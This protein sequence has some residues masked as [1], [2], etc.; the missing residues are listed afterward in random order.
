MA[1]WFETR[2]REL[3]D[4]ER[5]DPAFAT[6]IRALVVDEWK[7]NPA[8]I[9]PRH[10][11]FDVYDA[12]AEPGDIIMLD[13]EDPS[14][15]E[16]PASRRRGVAGRWLLVAASV[17]IVAIVG[18]LL[19]DDTGD[20]VDTAESAESAP[21]STFP[22][23]TTVAREV[24]IVEDF[25]PLEPG[26]W[27]ID[28]DGDDATP[29]RVSFD[30]AAERWESWLGTVKF[31][32]DG[33][34]ALTITTIDNLVRDGCSDHAPADPP[35]GP[36]VDELATALTQ[37]A[38][39]E[40]TSPPSDVTVLGYQGKQLQL[41]VP[42]IPTANERG[43]REFTGCTDGKLRSWF[44]PIHDDNTNSFFGYNA[45]PGRTEDFWILDVNGT[46]LVLATT[47]APDSPAQDVAELGAIFD[48]LRIEP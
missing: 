19:V 41:T 12:D 13:T 4:P 3:G 24:P 42:E 17:A 46:R 48:S 2:F 35:V 37:L 10:S 8:S 30:V 33:H 31:Y 14:A 21:A 39:F 6:R 25:V 26:R 45:E 32:P 44:S 1:D 27:F 18:T 9:P 28:P 43:G 36:T 15:L 7:A 34:V 38:P 47:T 29:L 11:D 23:A 22:P 5:L 40:V 20:E 16:D